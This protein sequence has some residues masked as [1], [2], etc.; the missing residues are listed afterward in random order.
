MQDQYFA[1]VQG[2]DNDSVYIY[3]NDAYTYTDSRSSLIRFPLDG[4]EPV[5][6]WSEN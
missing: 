1:W 2:V 3:F 6:L 4:S 5:V